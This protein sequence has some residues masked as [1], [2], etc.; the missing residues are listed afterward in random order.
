MLISDLTY[1][2]EVISEEAN[3][4]GGFIIPPFPCFPPNPS[5]LPMPSGNVTISGNIPAT[6]SVNYLGLSLLS[7][8]CV[9][10]NT[11]SVVG[12]AVATGN[13]TFTQY[14]P[15]AVVNPGY[16]QSSGAAYAASM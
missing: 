9:T 4:E 10:G 7:N 16:S 5:C 1:I 12:G 2:E 14:T 8:P 3:I 11:A 15:N 13:N 6:G